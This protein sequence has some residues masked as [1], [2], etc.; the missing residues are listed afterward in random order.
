MSAG[1]Y[2]VV[3]LIM[4][5][6]MGALDEQ[7]IVELFQVLVNTGMAW[8]LQGHYGRVASALIDAGLVTQPATCV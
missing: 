2:D 6:E 1:D 3:D 8:Q 5:Y 7:G 4:Q